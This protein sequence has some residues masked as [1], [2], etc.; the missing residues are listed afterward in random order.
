MIS[1]LINSKKPEIGDNYI[2]FA[3]NDKNGKEIKFSSIKSKYV[4][5]DFTWAECGAC[6]MALPELKEVYKKYNRE[7]T[8]ISFSND[9]N[10]EI[11]LNSLKRDSL[12]WLSLSNSRGCFDEVPAIY[13]VNA[14]P[15][16]FLLDSNKNV[17]DKWVG[18][19]IGQ[20]GIIGRV[21][22]LFKKKLR[23]TTATMCNAGC[24]S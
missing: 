12:E 14:Y 16:F 15:T 22:K 18:Y 6:K 23:T 4:L 2:D 24:S 9:R 19:G 5:L 8:I 21:E 7:I 20:R 10:K 11:W 17:I 3:A 13:G 1:T